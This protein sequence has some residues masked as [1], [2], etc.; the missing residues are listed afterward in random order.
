MNSID[1]AAELVLR[2]GIKD[3]GNCLLSDPAGRS[4]ASNLTPV[5][6]ASSPPKTAFPSTPTT[7]WA[8]PLLPA[9]IPHPAIRENS[10]PPTSTCGAPPSPNIAASPPN[11]PSWPFRPLPVPRRHLP[12]PLRRPPRL[13]RRRRRHRRTEKGTPPRHPRPALLQL[14]ALFPLTRFRSRGV[15]PGPRFGARSEFRSSPRHR[16]LPHD[17]FRSFFKLGVLSRV[18]S[19]SQTKNHRFPFGVLNGSLPVRSPQSVSSKHSVTNF[20]CPSQVPEHSAPWA[21]L[22][23]SHAASLSS[24]R[25]DHRQTNG[26]PYSSFWEILFLK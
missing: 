16:K 17:P 11:T 23:K 8:K 10:I 19:E 15:C 4:V 24:R 5:A 26:S 22:P 12:T 14:A 25:S 1:E 20:T 7:P 18:S 9:S 21:C 2:H 6:S 3:S 13:V